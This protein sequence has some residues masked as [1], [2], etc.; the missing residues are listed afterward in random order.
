MNVQIKATNKTNRLLKKFISLVIAAVLILSAFIPVTLSPMTSYAA[1]RNISL[2][3]SYEDA[4]TSTASSNQYF[5]DITSQGSI[6]IKFETATKTKTSSWRISLVSITDGKIYPVKDFGSGETAAN[7]SMRTE[8]S[9][10]MRLPAGKYYANV[11]VPEGYSAVENP[12]KISISFIPET[13]GTYETEH[14]NTLATATPLTLN[15]AM[16]GNLSYKGDVDYFKLTL[17]SPGSIN[18]SFSVAS[19]IDAG[20]WVVLL[21]DSKEKQLQMSRVGYLGEVSGLTRTNKLDKIRLPAGDYYIK[22]IAYSESLSS[23]A[24]YKISAAYAAEKSARYEKEFNDTDV[25]ATSILIN[26][27]IIGNMSSVDDRD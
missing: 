13:D 25:T 26:G 15:T 2:E 5:F 16:S 8:Y 14:N 21:Y 24:E 7:V 20:N 27:P 18:L 12:Y 17:P 6:L 22:I 1:S 11:S 3:N 23:S 10:R 4:L 9:D 19:T